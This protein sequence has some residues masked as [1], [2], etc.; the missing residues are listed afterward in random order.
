MG[1]ER[2][3]QEGFIGATVATPVPWKRLLYI[4]G[5]FICGLVVRVP[6][7]RYRGPGLISG[8]TRFF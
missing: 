8:A 6:G 2:P 7:Y 5:D 4:S 1:S 3:L